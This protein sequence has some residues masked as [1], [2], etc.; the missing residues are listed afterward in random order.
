M[1]AKRRSGRR[2]RAAAFAALG[3][4]TRLLLLA[5]LCSG[6]RQS[7]ADL[8][9]GTKLSRQ[10]VTKHLRVLQRVRMVHGAHAGRES[11]FEFDPRPIHEMQEYLET[12]SR[13]WDIALARLKKFVEADRR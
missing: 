6:E 7:I 9:K 5:K 4:P 8:T 2:D 12:V 11:L 10:A 13:D 3:D 1:F